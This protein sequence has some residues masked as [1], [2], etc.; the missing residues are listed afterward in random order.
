MKSRKSPISPG[1]GSRNSA[2]R[3]TRSRILQ[4]ALL[5][6]LT[7]AL[8]ALAG[9]PAN[10]QEALAAQRAL[11]A[12][13]PG[14]ASLLN[15]LGNLLALAGDLEEAEE[16]YRRALQSEPMD[17][18]SLYNLAL[19]LREQGENKQA[20]KTLESILEIDPRHSWTHY[21]LGDLYEDER[22]RKKAVYHYA[23]AFAADRSLTS[24]QVNPHIVENRLATDA[25]LAMYVQ[26]SPSTQAPRIYKEPGD[27]AEL[28][29]PQP[30]PEPEVLE[31]APEA[32]D[33]PL[34][35][36]YGATYPSVPPEDKNRIRRSSRSLV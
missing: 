15:D 20:R 29:L 31:A 2:A 24:P 3:T 30:V 33:V 4:G 19:V 14:D 21:Q 9:T 35:R 25:L 10:L 11:V 6:F 18:T 27:V 8:V 23:Q 16:T 22:N 5:V 12:E 7:S 13:H 26:E 34:R 28:L 17:V 32:E 36:R 1:D